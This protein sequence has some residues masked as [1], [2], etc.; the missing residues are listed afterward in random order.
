MNESKRN[1]T[2]KCDTNVSV[3]SIDRDDFVDIFMHV[4][5]GHEPEHISFLR[6]VDAFARWPVDQLPYHSPKICMLTYFRKNILMCANSYQNDWIYVVKQGNC[7][8]LKSISPICTFKMRESFDYKYSGK[9]L[10]HY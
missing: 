8:I 6:T 2:I 9:K 4:E 1:A 7:R 5:S 3:L 10:I